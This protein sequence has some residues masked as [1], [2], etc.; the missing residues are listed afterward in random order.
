MSCPNS[1]SV[2][3]WGSACLSLSSGFPAGVIIAS[4]PRV[5]ATTQSPYEEPP[6]RATMHTQQ[7]DGSPTLQPEGSNL[8]DLGQEKEREKS[9]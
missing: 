7:D 4:Q 2:L 9:V 8:E 6:R 3:G 5:G 1:H